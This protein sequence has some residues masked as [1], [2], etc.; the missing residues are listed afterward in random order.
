MGI[1][2]GDFFRLLARAVEGRPHEIDG[3]TIR[4]QDAA[5]AI[6]ITLSETT[7]RRIA[8]LSLPVTRVRFAYSGFT[9]EEAQAAMSRIDLHFQRGGG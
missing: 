2:H 8:L 6:E 9:P 1:D 3:A 5:G 4:I 7:E